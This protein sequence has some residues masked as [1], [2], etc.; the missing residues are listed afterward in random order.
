MVNK[1]GKSNTNDWMNRRN[2]LQ[3]GGMGTVALLA[4]CLGGDGNGDNG[5][6]G[7]GGNGNGRD[8]DGKVFIEGMGANTS[9]L[10]IHG[11]P[12]V[13]NSIAHSSLH[14]TLFTVNLELEPHPHLVDDFDRDE[15]AT[16]YDFYLREDV[17]F[18]DGNPLVA[19]SVVGTYERMLDISPE[20]YLLGPV[21]NIEAV[22]EYHVRM[23][24]NDPFPLLTRN[25]TS[26]YAAILSM[27][28]VEEAGDG[29][30]QDIAV[31]TGPFKFERWDR[32]ERIVFTKNEDYTWGPDFL[33]NTGPSH[34]DE[35]HFRYI[36]ESST[37]TNELTVGNVDGTTYVPTNDADAIADHEN[38]SLERLDFP[39]A[40][41]LA[42]NVTRPPTDDVNVRRAISHAINR[43]A[44]V[45]AAMDGEAYPI[46]NFVPPL[47]VNAL[48]ES[49]V[50][51][52]AHPYD[53][54]RA[55][56]LLEEAGWTNSS[57]G[58]VR[59]QDGEDLSIYFTA[60]SITQYARVGEVT[61]AMLSSVGF[62]VNLEVLEAGTLYDTLEASEHNVTTM[63]WSRSKFALDLLEPTLSPDNLA[64]EGGTNYSI[65]DNSEF[66][67]YLQTAR[68][69]PEESDRQQAMYDAQRLILEEVPV[70]PIMGYTKHYGYKNEVNLGDWF[71]HDWWPEQH[72]HHRLQVDL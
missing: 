63:A 28:A 9:T 43:Q 56:E 67:G 71:E 14:D 72:L 38:T 40:D 48:D 23:E 44:V 35:I 69:S 8:E 54:D 32:D 10:D 11:E 65:W 39:H 51:E 46:L 52:H 29:Y 53:P 34:L 42:L 16:Q 2:M 26:P 19:E 70:V 37:L 18:H 45:D 49:E 27:D 68:S 1:N 3:M 5:N 25:L 50:E 47:S 60:F 59:T 41:Y 57:E 31:G 12:R 66:A 15:D 7:N 4:G 33:E 30:G 21:E 61:Q 22:D 13:P 36:P 62:D 58:E 17:T 64:T 20:A 55:R 6:G 24:Y